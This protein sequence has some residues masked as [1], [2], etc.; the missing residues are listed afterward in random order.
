MHYHFAAIGRL[1]EAFKEYIDTQ[2]STEI[3]CD[4][5]ENENQLK[6]TLRKYNALA[7]FTIDEATDLSKLKWIHSFGAGVDGILH[8]KTLSPDTLITRTSGKMGIKMAEY[9]LTYILQELRNVRSLH[10]QQLV[11]IWEPLPYSNLYDQQVLIFGTGTIAQPIA[12]M[13][14]PLCKE[15]T[16]VNTNGSHSDFFDHIVIIDQLA[17]LNK[18]DIIINT[19]PLTSSTTHFFNSSFFDHCQN[20]LFINVGRG[21][22]VNPTDLLKALD[23]G[24]LRKAVLDVFETEPLPADNELWKHSGVIITPH[25]ASKTTIDDV[26]DS[27]EKIYEAL[28]QNKR[29][30]LI[31]DFNRGY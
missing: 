26:I 28:K 7:T 30:H 20:A 1:A 19:L 27:F 2:H 10:N 4:V 11:Q 17:E 21:K 14:K 9:C 29:P 3:T 12:T 6:Y 31:V 15:V 25:N 8:N 5:F 24:Q 13:L 23:S 22:S 16:G 18:Y